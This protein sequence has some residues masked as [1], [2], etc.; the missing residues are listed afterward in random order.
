MLYINTDGMLMLPNW[1]YIFH[2]TCRLWRH[3]HIERRWQQRVWRTR[4]SR[5]AVVSND[6]SCQSKHHST[7]VQFW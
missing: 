3:G 5:T 4:V 1:N 2:F 6:C 7:G